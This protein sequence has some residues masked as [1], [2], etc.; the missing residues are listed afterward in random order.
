[1]HFNSP[2][3]MCSLQMNTYF[4]STRS[5][6]FSFSSLLSWLLPAQLGWR[7]LG[8]R[9]AGQ[10]PVPRP[11][12]HALTL[13]LDINS[14]IDHVCL[15]SNEKESRELR[16]TPNRINQNQQPPLTFR[17]QKGCLCTGM[18]THIQTQLA[19]TPLLQRTNTSYR[20]FHTYTVEVASQQARNTN[21]PPPLHLFH[22][23]PSRSLEY[24]P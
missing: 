20:Y 15:K 10:Q 8:W 4:F 6:A 5:V 17:K 22:L 7:L 1:M 18:K 23:Q 24:D 11:V 12:R 3:I 19:H 9:G 14:S 21:S 16:K 2:P 13:Y